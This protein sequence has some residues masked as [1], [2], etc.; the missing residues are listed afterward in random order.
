MSWALHV[1]TIVTTVQGHTTDALP[2]F[3]RLT[4][5][6]DGNTE[7][8]QEMEDLLADAVRLAIETGGLG[9]AQSLAGRAAVLAAES[10]IPHR[11]ANV[12][13]CRGLLDHDAAPAAR[14]R[15]TL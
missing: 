4:E 11:H 3:D 7:E 14:G 9:T 6:F 1:L 8:V 12:L 5:A 2:L 15:G 13:Y 10:D